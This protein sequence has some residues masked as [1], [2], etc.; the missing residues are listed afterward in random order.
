MSP[1]AGFSTLQVLASVLGIG[2]CGGLLSRYVLPSG[3]SAANLSGPPNGVPASNSNVSAGAVQPESV[4]VPSPPNSKDPPVSAF[5]GLDLASISALLSITSL[6]A[7][8]ALKSFTG[9]DKDQD[10][11]Q[12]ARK[13]K[14]DRRRPYHAHRNEENVGSATLD[15]IKLKYSSVQRKFKDAQVQH[16]LLSKENSKWRSRCKSLSSKLSRT[17]TKK[18]DQSYSMDAPKVTLLKSE[19]R[20]LKERLRIARHANLRLSDQLT[21]LKEA[22]NRA[23][24][25]SDIFGKSR[26]VLTAE[27]QARLL[28]KQE[29]LLGAPGANRKIVYPKSPSTS[30]NV[31]KGMLGVHMRTYKKRVG[32]KVGSPK[33]D[34][35]QPGVQ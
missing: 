1:S 29:Q 32:V 6:A 21:R 33:T 15:N 12:D 17:D 19:N 3:M 28:V 35:K 26:D 2:A 10:G 34:R 13:P 18:I 30:L 22:Y 16:A 31:E 7:A 9:P 11:D 8:F 25:R 20:Q 24:P 14:H 4:Q 5:G 27:R 23:G